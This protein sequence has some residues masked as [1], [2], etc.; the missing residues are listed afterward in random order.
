MKCGEKGIT[1]E[2]KQLNTIIFY[3]KDLRHKDKDVKF[4]KISIGH[5]LHCSDIYSKDLYIFMEDDMSTKI[6][7]SRF[8]GIGEVIKRSKYL[9]WL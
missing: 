2:T 7:K 1:M 5:F 4:R 9:N 8:T 3:R 6:L